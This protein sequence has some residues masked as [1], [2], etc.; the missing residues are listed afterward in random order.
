MEGL[1]EERKELIID[2]MSMGL[3]RTYEDGFI[4]LSGEYCKACPKPSDNVLHL[5][6]RRILRELGH[7][8]I[9]YKTFINKHFELIVEEFYTDIPEEKDEFYSK[10]WREYSEEVY[11]ENSFEEHSDGEGH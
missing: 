11:E 1:T 3:T 2:L 6:I 10:V 8:L 7:K 5:T 4:I 9:K